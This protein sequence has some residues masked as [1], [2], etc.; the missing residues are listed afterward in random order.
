MKMGNI[1][2]FSYFID[3]SQK[4]G[5]SYILFEKSL[6]SKK[7]KANGLYIIHMAPFAYCENSS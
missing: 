5:F 1:L 3:K 6:I 7:W 2:D 4:K